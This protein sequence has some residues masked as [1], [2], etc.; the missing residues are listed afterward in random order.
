MAAPWPLEQ[1]ERAVESLVSR[2]GGPFAD[3]QSMREIGSQFPF[4]QAVPQSLA[5]ALARLVGSAAIFACAH[6]AELACMQCHTK[7]DACVILEGYVT[8]MGLCG[9]I[10]RL[11]HPPQAVHSMAEADQLRLLSTPL[12]LAVRAAPVLLRGLQDGLPGLAGLW[13]RDDPGAL[14]IILSQSGRVVVDACI[15][16]ATG[17]LLPRVARTL[18]ATVMSPSDL[19][20]WVAG[21][22]S[23]AQAQLDRT[24]LQHISASAISALSQVLSDP[25]MHGAR[26]AA[27]A[28]PELGQALLCLLRDAT[29]AQ[30]ARL[31]ARPLAGLAHCEADNELERIQSLGDLFCGGTTPGVP[32]GAQLRVWKPFMAAQPESLLPPAARLFLA[33][34]QAL[35]AGSRMAPWQLARAHLVWSAI[36]GRLADL[37]LQL[38]R[39]GAEAA[40]CEQA[41]EHTVVAEQQQQQQRSAGSQG[42]QPVEQQGEQPQLWRPPLCEG[43]LEPAAAVVQR[44]HW[45]LAQVAAAA[46]A[47]TA[48]Q[49]ASSFQAWQQDDLGLA[50][51]LVR[52]LGV[53][54]LQLPAV[55][56]DAEQATFQLAVTAC[57]CYWW[58][59]EQRAGESGSSAGSAGSGEMSSK[60]GSTTLPPDEADLLTM[61]AAERQHFLALGCALL[62]MKT[63]VLAARR[64]RS[65]EEPERRLECLAL[66]LL[67]VARPLEVA[68]PRLEGAPREPAYLLCDRLD[69]SGLL[70]LAVLLPRPVAKAWGLDSLLLGSIARA[71]EAVEEHGLELEL[72]P[73]LLCCLQFLLKAPPLAADLAADRP[74]LRHT[75]RLMDSLLAKSWSRL[76]ADSSSSVLAAA[77]HDVVIKGAAVLQVLGP[78]CGLP[79]LP[80][81]EV[82]SGSDDRENKPEWQLWS[83]LP[84]LAA[85]AAA[86]EPEQVS[87]GDQWC[88]TRQRQHQTAAAAAAGQEACSEEMPSQAASMGCQ[89]P[90]AGQLALRQAHALA[91]RRCGNPRQPVGCQRGASAHSRLLARPL[92]R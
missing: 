39:S 42:G 29:R 18:D 38:R 78:A 92:L 57:K 85:L 6:A 32:S 20:A 2:F 70:E 65:G 80:R 1:L 86:A 19:A 41:E 79:L 3:W 64:Q 90:D 11:L 61:P 4:V 43:G 62:A 52:Q 84:Q 73:R 59:T 36:V 91:E 54:V 31:Q 55:P 21:A 24:G 56:A 66:C 67:E 83:T 49:P 76:Q 58:H 63:A 45:L 68:C 40:P 60:D 48:L 89:P 13:Q 77:H 71:L 87:T 44:Q 50:L 72:G 16:R 81:K 17:Q 15:I 23:A 74:L 7:S 9:D 30:A 51:N 82:P 26:E 33:L 22:V 27:L 69:R 46:L 8:M 47:E 14:G 34:P 35:P 28:Q 5:S 37:E 75:L 12:S 53:Q 88:L 25:D 10:L